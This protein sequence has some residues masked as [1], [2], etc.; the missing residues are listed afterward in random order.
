MPLALPFS[1]SALHYRWITFKSAYLMML[2]PTVYS[3][4]NTL[5]C[6]FI[7]GPLYSLFPFS[8]VETCSHLCFPSS[9]LPA[10]SKHPLL[11]SHLLGII[12]MLAFQRPDP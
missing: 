6:H 5:R 3:S 1:V 8:K 7:S 11:F 2:F 10:S 9:L 4:Y 12:S